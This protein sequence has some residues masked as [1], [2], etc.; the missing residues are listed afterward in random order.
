MLLVTDE[1]ISVII[2]SRINSHL[3][4]G[5][6]SPVGLPM[7]HTQ[8]YL[9]YISNCKTVMYA[10]DKGLCGRNVLQSSCY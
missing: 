5:H 9:Y 1:L 8:L 3:I 2:C 4:A 6:F 7:L 10:G